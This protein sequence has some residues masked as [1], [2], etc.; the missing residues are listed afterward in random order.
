[1][2]DY[3]TIERDRITRQDAGLPHFDEEREPL[4]Q[5]LQQEEENN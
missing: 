1:M 2:P 4:L 5:V 3:Q